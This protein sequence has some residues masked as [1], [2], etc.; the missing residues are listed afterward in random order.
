MR[1]APDEAE[2]HQASTVDSNRSGALLAGRERMGTGRPYGTMA[3]AK[4]L[5]FSHYAWPLAYLAALLTVRVL[6]LRVR[7][8][9]G[10]CQEMQA[11]RQPAC[12][13]TCTPASCNTL[14]VLQRQ[15]G[16]PSGRPETC[17]VPVPTG[18]LPQLALFMPASVRALA[19]SQH[20]T[21][22]AC[23]SR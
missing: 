3:K 16:A 8:P 23:S 6:L 10:A 7:P 2:A 19:P 17:P 22:S 18:H 1:Q 4:A 13:D 11:L 20:A 14:T 15:P 12:A 21:R 5:L 9:P